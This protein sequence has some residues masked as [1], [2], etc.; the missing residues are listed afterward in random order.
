MAAPKTMSPIIPAI[1]FSL[2]IGGIGGYFVRA[3]SPAQASQPVPSTGSGGGRGGG[4]G[5]G[6]GGMGGMGF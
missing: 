5:G 2:L 6:M 4:G 3:Y 1:V